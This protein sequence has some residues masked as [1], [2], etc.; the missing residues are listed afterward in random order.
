[1]YKALPISSKWLPTPSEE[2]F[3]LALFNSYCER[4][5]DYTGYPLRTNIRK[6]V[7]KHS[8]RACSG[9]E[10][11]VKISMDQIFESCDSRLIV[12]LGIPGVG[13]STLAL[14][15]CRQWEDLSSMKQYSLVIL[16]R[17]REKRVQKIKDVFG[18]FFSCE[19]N[20]KPLVDEI[21][22][23][24]GKGVL[25]VLDGLDELPTDMR[26]KG[27]LIDLIKKKV[28][29][30]SMVV[31]TSRPS[32]ANEL[33]LSCYTCSSHSHSRMIPKCIELMGF[34][35]ENVE[36]YVSDI[37]SDP[38]TVE[39][40]KEYIYQNPAINSPMCIP[41]N[42]AIIVQIYADS[43]SKSSLPYSLT[44]LYTQLCLTILDNYMKTEHPSVCVNKFEDLPGDL[45][46]CFLNLAEIAFEGI[47]KQQIVFNRDSVPS[48]INHFGFLDSVCT[49]YGSSEISYNFLHLTLQ[50]FFAAL[51][52][53]QLPDRGAALFKKY[54][55]LDQWSMVWRFVAGLTGFQHLMDCAS[56]FLFKKDETLTP[57]F[58]QS[59]FEARIVVDFKSTFGVESKTFKFDNVTVSHGTYSC[60]QPYT[61]PFNCFALGYCIANCTTKQSI[62]SVECGHTR[63]RKKAFDAFFQALG[64]N[65]SSQGVMESYRQHPHM[66]ID[67]LCMCLA[68]SETPLNRLP[69]LLLINSLFSWKSLVDVIPHF[70]NLKKLNIDGTR[71]YSQRGEK[72][73][74]PEFLQQLSHSQVTSLSVVDTGIEHYLMR[75]FLA[76]AAFRVLMRPT[77]GKLQELFMGGRGCIDSSIVG[78]VSSSSSLRCLSL[79]YPDD[80]FSSL[81]FFNPCNQ[82]S[83]LTL[84]LKNRRDT[85]SKTSFVPGV[86]KI[87]QN[88][89]ALKYLQLKN[90]NFSE[91]Y[92][93]VRDIAI[94]LKEN[95]TLETLRFGGG[96]DSR[97]C[98]GRP[99]VTI[100]AD[101]DPAAAK[102]AH[103][104]V[105]S[106][107]CR[108]LCHRD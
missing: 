49:L 5:D 60:Y 36:A 53:S 102:K 96:S 54:H 104:L 56:L 4:K 61:T 85:C 72:D 107:D 15:L 17:L 82:L 89:K 105:H 64:T 30:D 63:G 8:C 10:D 75:G 79:T 83:K 24:R 42:T 25:F 20:R 87:L 45:Y 71:A 73:F 106:I 76:L 99:Y 78:V 90:F 93:A 23:C 50:E 46:K 13:K 94:A 108:A 1:M 31:V 6:P 91:D 19:I 18:L 58:I 32:A 95:T 35:R 7:S 81:D 66:D 80:K 103:K 77:S 29:P 27:F 74:S 34:T 43:E 14:E 86:V 97:R 22:S 69:N 92:C 52:I 11:L 44:Q 51:Y 16:L 3:E 39:S 28:L 98:G 55:S 101:D 100:S 68:K 2:S 88:S 65:P 33:V 67:D 59:L 57:L 12:V 40:F 62:W 9:R 21:V 38:E 70:T 41:I 48:S 47:K 84:A 37:F 26:H